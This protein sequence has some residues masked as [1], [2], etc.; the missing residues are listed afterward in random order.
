ML[1]EAVKLCIVYT[2]TKKVQHK[3]EN[4]AEKRRSNS[5]FEFKKNSDHKYLSLKQMFRHE[6]GE[7]RSGSRFVILCFS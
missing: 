7:K 5:K 4:I 2:Q 1:R 3:M 6:A